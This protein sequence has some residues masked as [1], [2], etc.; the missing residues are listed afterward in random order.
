MAMRTWF[1]SKEPLPDWLSGLTWDVR[2]CVLA[3]VR[4][5]VWAGILPGYCWAGFVNGV[6]VQ[7]DWLCC[8][9]T[10]RAAVWMVVGQSYSCMCLFQLNWRCG[11]LFRGVDLPS[12]WLSGQAEKHAGTMGWSVIW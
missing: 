1:L 6:I 12:L 8:G 9:L 4:Q 7:T 10:G 3:G 2:Y 5:A 11:W